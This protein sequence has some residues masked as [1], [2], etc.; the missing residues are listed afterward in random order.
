MNI[1]IPSKQDHVL[2]KGSLVVFNVSV[3]DGI[4]MQAALAFRLDQVS[5]LR[6][7]GVFL[8]TR[9]DA[10]NFSEGGTRDHRRGVILAGPTN[11]PGSSAPLW[12]RR[13]SCTGLDAGFRRSR[14][15]QRTLHGS[16]SG[17]QLGRRPAH[18][19]AAGSKVSRYGLEQ[20]EP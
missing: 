1:K 4:L 17:H 10:M 13:H 20:M 19:Q 7:R 18:T 9:P 11:G 15:P 5:G 14:P 2:G 6:R 16:G 12:G 3:F 8:Q